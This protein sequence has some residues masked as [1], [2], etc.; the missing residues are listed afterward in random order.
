MGRILLRE[1]IE[2]ARA[3]GTTTLTIISNTVLKPAIHLYKA[4]GFVEVPLDSDRGAVRRAAASVAAMGPAELLKLVL[5][6]AARIAGPWTPTAPASLAAAYEFAASR[7]A[8]ASVT[9]PT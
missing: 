1:V 9:I 8:I 5:E 4:M 6:A 2:G 7:R 3:L